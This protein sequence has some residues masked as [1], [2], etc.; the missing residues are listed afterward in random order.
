MNADGHRLSPEP[1]P[2]LASSRVALAGGCQE[3]GDLRTE[4]TERNIFAKT[5]LLH[6]CST[7]ATENAEF[8]EGRNSLRTLQFSVLQ[9]RKIIAF[10]KMFLSVVPISSFFV[11]DSASGHFDFCNLTSEVARPPF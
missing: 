11:A 7:E 1:N 3:L 10:A 5:T 2:I 6:P 9:S 8:G 4:A